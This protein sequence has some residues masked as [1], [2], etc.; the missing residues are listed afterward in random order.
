MDVN[1]QAFKTL[2]EKD[3]KFQKLY[4]DHVKYEKQL[5]ELDRIYY[6]TPEQE[7]QRKT[8]QKLKLNGK[9]QMSLLIRQVKA[10]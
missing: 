2:L 9:D 6:L 1:S 3:K 10:D 8:I 4:E 7:V 5:G